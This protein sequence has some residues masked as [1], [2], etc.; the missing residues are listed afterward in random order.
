MLWA[1]WGTGSK[2]FRSQ[3]SFPAASRP[4]LSPSVPQARVPSHQPTSQGLA[5]QSYN[6]EMAEGTFKVSYNWFFLSC[7]FK[8]L[9]PPLG[10]GVTMSAIDMVQAMRP[11]PPGIRTI[12]HYFLPSITQNLPIHPDPVLLLSPHDPT[13]M[14]WSWTE[15]PTSPN[16]SPEIE[17]RSKMSQHR[18]A[19]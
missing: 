11:K 15:I 10:F 1:R 16:L 18:N 4:P 19:A 14:S 8:I 12:G 7:C 13:G 5:K 9:S 3:D 17:T 6:C 2:V